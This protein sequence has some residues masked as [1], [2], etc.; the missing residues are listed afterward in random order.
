MALGLGH[1][2]ESSALSVLSRAYRFETDASVRL[3]IVRALS[4]RPE[5]ARERA[6]ALARNLDS[7]SSVREAATLGLAHAATATEQPG[8][9]SL[10][11]ELVPAEGAAPKASVAT[12]HG[13]LVSTASGLSLP[14]FA[15][16]DGVL[17]LPALPSGPFELRL[18]AQA[19]TDN[20]ENRP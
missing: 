6:L 16:P 7:S 9:D 10:W 11:L 13:A 1:S 18:A 2:R 12:V 3:A 14:A 17:L 20:A 4:I 15:D 8:P 19:R 5:P